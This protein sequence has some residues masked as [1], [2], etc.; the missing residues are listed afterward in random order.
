MQAGAPHP[1]C[2]SPQ[3]NALSVAL[4]VLAVAFQPRKGIA[5]YI[6]VPCIPSAAGTLQLLWDLGVTWYIS[7][8]ALID[9]GQQEENTSSARRIPNPLGQKVR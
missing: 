7:I 6:F 2:D 5:R 8:L 9:K 3:K 1:C 4:L